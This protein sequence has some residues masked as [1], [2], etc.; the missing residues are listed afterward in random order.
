MLQ[1]NIGSQTEKYFLIVA[2]S[3][4]PMDL[5]VCTFP[6]NDCFLWVC[7]EFWLLVDF[8]FVMSNL[9]VNYLLNLNQITGLADT[10]RLP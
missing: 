9:R 5:M 3:N 1:P 4:Q 2:T 10:S 7:R 6:K 8:L